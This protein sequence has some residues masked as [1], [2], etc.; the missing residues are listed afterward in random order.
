MDVLEEFVKLITKNQ[1]LMIQSEVT[2]SWKFPCPQSIG[3]H[4]I[5]NGCCAL[6]L[7][8]DAEVIPLA[9]GDLIFLAQGK[10]HEILPGFGMGFKSQ[11]QSV[12][13]NCVVE[14]KKIA[15]TW[16][17]GLYYLHQKF[18]HPFLTK[19]PAYFKVSS[20]T[21]VESHPLVLAVAL[22]K[23]ELA[24]NKRALNKQNENFV[25]LHCLVT[26]LFCYLMQELRLRVKKDK[27]S[28]KKNQWIN[29]YSDKFIGEAITQLNENVDFKW[30]VEVMAEKTGLSRSA[31][32]NRFKVLTGDTPVNYLATIRIQKAIEYLKSE[33]GDIEGIAGRVGYSSAFS[34]S[35]AFKRIYGV[36]PREF[37]KQLRK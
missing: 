6:R 14:E 24:S 4:I 9:S 35:K 19:T 12:P 34:F 25:V 29:A 11:V 31:F 7:L 27:D 13:L 21:L 17:T 22:L 23:A 15:T 10:R 16:V 30:T 2:D 18:M 33:Q 1:K 8:D 28:V 26:T 37:R 36:S 20:S 32:A 3:F 5:L